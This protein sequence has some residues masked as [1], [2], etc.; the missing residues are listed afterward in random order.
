[1]DK[2]IEY[3]KDEGIIP[4][5]EEELMAMQG[6]DGGADPALGAT[7][8]DPEINSS[9]VEPPNNKGVI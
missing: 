6:M 5:S 9:A 8:M 4:P 7:P 2:R 3:E 1:M